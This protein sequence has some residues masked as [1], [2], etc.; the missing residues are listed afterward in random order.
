MR[1]ANSRERDGILV[2]TGAGL[3]LI[4]LL[5]LQS[6]VGS[7]LL[8]TRTVTSTAAITTVST[9]PEVYYQVASSY[10]N[11]LYLLNSSYSFAL[12]SDYE[13]NATIDVRGVMPGLVGSYT[14]QS[15]ISIF[16]G[17][18]R[19]KF[20]NFSVSNESQTIAPEGS[21]WVVNST[22][23][24][25]AYSSVVGNTDMAIAAEDSYAHVGNAWLIAH[26]TWNFLKFDEQFPVG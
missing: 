13:S 8:S 21:Y 18:F 23:E 1:A 4:A 7:G 19:E 12:K 5:V 22:F 3:T 26:E 15:N 20:L 16:L 24:V 14:G 2:G 6:L 10:A 9:V 17:S 11:H 25:H